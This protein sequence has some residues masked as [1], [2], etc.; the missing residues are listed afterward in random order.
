MESIFFVFLL[1]IAIFLWNRAGDGGDEERGELCRA[2]FGG[3]GT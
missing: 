2:R 1:I 3:G